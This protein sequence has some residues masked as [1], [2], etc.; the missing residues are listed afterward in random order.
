MLLGRL[1]PRQWK[2]TAK[3]IV[4]FVTIFVAAITLIGGM[5]I[6]SQSA[7]LSEMLDKKAEIIARNVALGVGDVF[8]VPDQAQRLI[9][10][11]KKFDEA[12]S[13]L[14]LVSNDGGIVA[15]TDTAARNSRG[16]FDAGALKA[17]NFMRRDTP[18]AGVFEVVIPVKAGTH[19]LGVLRIG[20]SRRQVEAQTRSAAIVMVGVSFLAL[21]V[22]IG[23]Y[24][25]V[26]RRVARPLGQAVE[27]LYQLARGDADL[28]LRLAVKS[29]DET[30]QL[31]QVLNRFLDNIHDLVHEIR[32][33]AIE[34]ASASRHLSAG[35]AQLSSGSQEQASSLE[36]T[37]ASLEEIT[38]TV[39]QNADNAKQVNQ[40]AMGSRDVAERGGQVVDTA[41]A[42]MG[43]INKSSKKIA[44]IITTIDEIAFQ[45][46]LLALNAAVEAARAGE[47]GRG[48]A[49]VAS[50][51][52]N[53]AQRSATA[54]K[55]IKALIQ[56][57][58]SK[59]ES[60]SELVTKSGATLG[61]IVSSVKRVTDIVG[62]IAA[63]S[64]EQSSGIDQVN[65]AV[66]QMDRVVQFNA[67]QS[68]ELS[69]TA[70]ALT[71]QAG[72]LQALVARF[73]LSDDDGARKEM[74]FDQ[75]SEIVAEPKPISEAAEPQGEAPAKAEPKP[76]Y[77][78]GSAMRH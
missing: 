9:E 60:G 4:P 72:E 54:A 8:L 12:V 17:E 56:D 36:E 40:L 24:L 43:E 78:I 53:L 25:W 13:Y 57:S 45:T 70:R 68:E 23:I 21:I 39:K 69:S 47:Q 19:R 20:I 27:R 73:K 2:I 55:E 65:R 58:V 44:D 62:E 50:E 22:G 71:A 75:Q 26:A 59:V 67:A 16:E 52:R 51:V 5:F 49:V 77:Y 35:V 38:G 46:N 42:A 14:M 29:S 7:S 32:D 3:L 10:A 64:G 37:A 1:R 11:A 63:A 61:E 6:R 41:V 74:T 31:A 18:T 30:G 66:T 33:M 34:V 28:T 48:F 15:T 76:V